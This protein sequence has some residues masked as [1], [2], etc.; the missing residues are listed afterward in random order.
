M[1]VIILGLVILAVFAAYTIFKRFKAGTY[2]ADDTMFS[3]AGV[4]VYLKKQKIEIK[5]RE[6]EIDSIT[7]I[8]TE[9]PS[10]NQTLAYD[11]V[12]SLSDF[13]LPEHRIR[14]VTASKANQ[15]MQRLTTAIEKA[16]GP[17]FR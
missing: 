12:I 2:K 8:R 15:F 10:R 7:N 11:C 4:T 3:Q 17:S 5:G 14:F 13:K 6:F 9:P 1:N 16:G